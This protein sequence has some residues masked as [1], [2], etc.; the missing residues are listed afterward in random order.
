MA[1]LVLPM[2]RRTSEGLVELE[3]REVLPEK[4]GGVKVT[5]AIVSCCQST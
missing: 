1:A 3:E 4:T 2:Q 5:R